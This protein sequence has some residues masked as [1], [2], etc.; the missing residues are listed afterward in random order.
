MLPPRQLKD[1]DILLCKL[2]KKG[3]DKYV[4][5]YHSYFYIEML[6][7]VVCCLDVIGRCVLFGCYWALCVV[8]MLLG[9]VCCLD[10]IGRCVLFV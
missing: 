2:S 4:K 5:E 7:G 3:S 1:S 6:L 10:V 9:V 8:W